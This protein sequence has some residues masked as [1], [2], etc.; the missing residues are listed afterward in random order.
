MGRCEPRPIGAMTDGRATQVL[1][2]S[3]GCVCYALS[4]IRIKNRWTVARSSSVKADKSLV[5]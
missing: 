1:Q 2:L 3:E 5:L 4:A